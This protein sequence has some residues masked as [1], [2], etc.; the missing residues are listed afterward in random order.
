MIL[1]EN[2]PDKQ[3]LEQV[4]AERIPPRWESDAEKADVNNICFKFIREA[5]RYAEDRGMDAEL[6]VEML[7]KE[8]LSRCLSDD[9][10]HTMRVFD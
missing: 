8:I 1:S 9:C 10:D 5:K 3:A 7:A 6:F 4:L 2:Q